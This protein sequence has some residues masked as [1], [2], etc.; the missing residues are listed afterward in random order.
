MLRTALLTA[1]MLS[2]LA[3]NAQDTLRI[4]LNEADDL[5]RT[6]SLELIAQHYAIDQAEADRVQAR[7]FNNPS[8][9]TE[10]SVRPS[11]GRFFDVA[12]PSGQKA[13]SVEQL[14][15]IG[16]QRSLAVKAAAQRT[17]LSEAEYSELAAALKYQLHGALYRQYYLD[18]AI[19]SISSQLVVL[20]N[21]VDGYGVQ[22]EKGNVSLR[23]VTRLRTSFFALNGQRTELTRQQ[24]AAQE[25][26][27]VLLGELRPVRFMPSPTDLV[28]IRSLPADT[29]Q[30][31][32]N[33]EAQRPRLLAANASAEA[34]DLEL[35]YQ[36][37]M[38]LPDLALGA[39]Y[40]QNSNYL[41]N[42]TGLNAGISIPL[43]DRNQG[44]IARAR[45]ASA[46]A[47]TELQ[48]ERLTVRREVQRTYNDLHALQDQ[49]T[50]TTQGFGQQLDQ[51]SESLIDNY[52]KSN[53]SLIEF[54]DLFES[55]TASIIALNLLEAD[56]Q[57]A[58]EELEFVSAQRVFQR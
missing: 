15:R 41:H 28:A 23:E 17:V 55:Y 26:L 51:L 53:I 49:Y 6:R 39:T 44:R 29:A 5:L 38:A 40:D 54:T 19:A 27:G 22:L 47:H 1:G 25:D 42:Y 30:L 16:G 2:L 11:T 46:Q 56:L 21:I 52:V 43:F 24:N 32:A 3:G 36:R 9:S 57:N 20:K 34:S 14:F 58:Y 12:Q 8:L 50:N 45:A 48:L 10:W 35:K 31:I 7:L 18:R 4:S 37:R 13:V 33:A